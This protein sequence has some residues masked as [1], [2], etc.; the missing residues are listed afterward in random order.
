MAEKAS[1]LDCIGSHWREIRALLDVQEVMV[2]EAR[3]RESV[4]DA[5][6]RGMLEMYVNWQ[7]TL[8]VC[9]EAQARMPVV[10]DLENMLRCVLEINE[11]MMWEKLASKFLQIGIPRRQVSLPGCIVRCSATVD[12][13]KTLRQMREGTTVVVE[14]VA[15]N[16]VRISSPVKGWVW[17]THLKPLEQAHVPHESPLVTPASLTSLTVTEL[18]PGHSAG[19]SMTESMSRGIESICDYEDDD[20]LFGLRPTIHHSSICTGSRPNSC[21]DDQ[22]HAWRYSSHSERADKLFKVGDRVRMRDGT[23]KPWFWGRVGNVSSHCVF[24]RREGFPAMAT[25]RCV[26]LMEGP[27][28]HEHRN[29]GLRSVELKVQKRD[30]V[31]LVID[32]VDLRVSDV[33]PGSSAESAGLKPGM[34]VLSVSR[35]GVSSVKDIRALISQADGQFSIAIAVE[36]DSIANPA[37]PFLQQVDV[38]VGVDEVNLPLSGGLR[39][40]TYAMIPP[41]STVPPTPWCWHSCILNS[42]SAAAHGL[43]QASSFHLASL[44]P[45]MRRNIVVFLHLARKK[46]FV[47]THVYGSLIDLTP[48]IA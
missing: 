43:T 44:T 40:D 18:T 48:T 14:E 28:P 31:G 10:I 22:S 34:K 39:V 35:M 41:P 17:R 33:M 13:R 42:Y 37:Q 26:Q 24:V 4:C 15:G 12:A 29:P 7:R 9:E 3:G 32:P 30:S 11:E 38:K 1:M 25:W 36:D 21:S 27:S 20:S 6:A 8:T 5:E 45:K 46:H 47:P 16:W 2:E 19:D 23:D